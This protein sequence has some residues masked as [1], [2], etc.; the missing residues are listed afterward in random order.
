MNVYRFRDRV[1]INP[2]KGPTIYLDAQG[3]RSLAGLL[4]A[5]VNDLEDRSFQES[6]FHTTHIEGN[7]E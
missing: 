7:A 3:A 5:C 2:P 1:A 4:D 6:Q